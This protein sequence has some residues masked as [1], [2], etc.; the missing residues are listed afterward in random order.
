MRRDPGFAVSL[1]LDACTLGLVKRGA[2]T[3]LSESKILR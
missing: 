3:G 2:P 1:A